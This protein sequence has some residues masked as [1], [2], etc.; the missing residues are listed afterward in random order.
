MVHFNQEIIDRFWLKVSVKDDSCWLW[1]GAKTSR[2]YG[3]FYLSP[4]QFMLAHRFS[5]AIAN[6]INLK[7]SHVCHH[8]DTPLCVNP[9]HLFLGTAL[10]NMRDMIQKG[11]ARHAK[12]EESGRAI[13]T[14]KDVG[15]IRKSKESV[16][17]LARR[18]GVSQGCISS[19]IRGVTWKHVSTPPQRRQLTAEAV[20]LI[21][22]LHSKGSTGRTLA[23]KFHVSEGLISGIINGKVWKYV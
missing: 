9:N 18:Y 7:D 17:I 2:G 11:R 8:C 13:L 19:A 20:K 6:N 21:R 3:Q 10:S 16:P 14:A 1:T 5:F 4:G 15:A 23:K 12:G 22:K